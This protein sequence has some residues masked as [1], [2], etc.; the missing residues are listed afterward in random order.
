MKINSVRLL[1]AACLLGALSAV[2]FDSSHAQPALFEDLSTTDFEDTSLTTANWNT[3]SGVLELYAFAPRKVGGK[4]YGTSVKG[5]AVS[6]DHVLLGLASSNLQV[7]NISDPTLPFSEASISTGAYV[8]GVTVVGNRA[9]VCAGPSGLQIYDLQNPA[10]PILLGSFST[11]G[12]ARK[13][14][15]AGS[16]I[17]VV[18]G[19]SLEI[20]DARNPAAPVRIGLYTSSGLLRGV[21]VRGRHAY[22]ASG[23]AGLEILDVSNPTLPVQVGAFNSVGY[24]QDLRVDGHYV[25]VVSDTAGLQVFDVTMPTAPVLV[26]SYDTPGLARGLDVEGTTAYVAD[27]SSGLAVVD[28]S[29]PTLPTLMFQVPTAGF[30]VSVEVEGSHAYVADDTDGLGVYEVHQPVEPSFRSSHTIAGFMQRSDVVDGRAY[31][32]EGSN[33]LEILDVVDPAMPALGAYLSPGSVG[34]VTVVGTTAFLA[35]GN[36][37]LEVVDVTNPGTPSL[38]GTYGDVS[39]AQA[40]QI[41]GNFAFV[42]SGDSMLVV[43]VANVGAPTLVS[44]YSPAGGGI[45]Y[46]LRVV[47]NRAYISNSAQD[48]VIVD[49]SD[50]WVPIGVTTVDLPGGPSFITSRRAELWGNYAYVPHSNVGV[51]VVDLQTMSPVATIPGHFDAVSVQGDELFAVERTVG[52]QVF[53]I[54]DP[55]A[56]I[57]TPRSYALGTQGVDVQVHDERAYLCHGGAFEIVEVAQ[58]RLD[59][60]RNVGVSTNWANS[61]GNIMRARLTSV[62]SGAVNWEL[63]ADGGANWASFSPTNA[64]TS[65]TFTG[66]SLRWRATLDF[67]GSV[68]PS[69]DRLQIDVVG[70]SARIE[71]ITDVGNDQ[72]RQVRLEWSRS[73]HDFAGDSTQITQYAVYRKI[74]AGLAPMKAAPA[75]SDP[76]ASLAPD[77]RDRVAAMAAAGWD[78]VTAV[79]VRVQ[80][81]YAVVVPTMADSSIV[82]GQ[83]LSTFM[84]SA[85]TATPGVFFDSPPD[86]GYSVDNLAPG[87]PQGVAATYQAAG[88]TLDWADNPEADLRFYR[89]YR[90]TTP[91][92]APDGAHLVGESALSA[93][94]D[95]TASP[96]GYAYKVSAVD[97]SGNESLLSSPQSATDVPTTEGL[98]FALHEAVPNPFNPRT[99]LSYSLRS[100]GPVQL[101]IYNAAGR[102][103]RTLV[104]EEQA[105]GDYRVE[106]AGRDQSGRGVASGV[107]YYE[108]RSKGQAERRPMVLLK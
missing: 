63:S 5:L 62:E 101:I 86:S 71:A 11:V 34:D 13:V 39:W 41:Q 82:S 66:T 65:L 77:L 78:F 58:H 4:N 76:V 80:D 87:P 102:V 51:V 47:G 46:S 23:F 21:E 56:P 84:V 16:L 104:D 25:Y 6:G 73:G 91:G 50:P 69:V 105:A 9:F 28:L 55:T 43:D 59:L 42:T 18:S 96:W 49:I 99:T 14:Y 8:D 70:E 15:A 60:F 107:Y 97:Y 53:D 29:N 2:S 95:P 20:L 79:P 83:H 81:R 98:R 100:T 90:G 52:L 37:G 94:T 75:S 40:V 48:L 36:A 7:V 61:I 103:V 106:W 64:W 27:G 45:N 12:D 85:L 88:V 19:S 44:S 24:A 57:S 3:S 1:V 54:S 31:V 67:Q 108:L 38:L 72:G 92:F 22:L 74:E 93:W 17:Y 32:A 89:I 35:S 33:G 30:A 10:S 26:G 68:D